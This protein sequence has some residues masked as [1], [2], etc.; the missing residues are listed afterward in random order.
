MSTDSRR[1]HDVSTRRVIAPVGRAWRRR[2]HI[3]VM[4]LWLSGIL[5][6]VTDVAAG[7]TAF[8]GFLTG[9]AAMIGSAKGTAIV[10]LLATT[11]VTAVAMTLAARGSA[12]A[13]VVWLGGLG[14]I[15]Y[16]AQMFVYGTPLNSLFLLYVAALGLSVWSIVWLTRSNT[17]GVVAG[18]V[19]DWMPV[20]PIAVYVWAVAAVNALAWLR[21]LVPALLSADPTIVL[22]GTGLTTNPVYVQDLAFW[23]PLAMVAGVW[24]WRRR[25]AGYVIVGALLAMWVLESISVAVDQW[26]GYRGDPSST[27]VSLTM[28][29]VFGAL[30]AVG[31]LV[32]VI[33][34][35][36]VEPQAKKPLHSG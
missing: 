12:R 26:F 14:T 4:C 5:L 21:V 10:L 34:L 33:H 1:E 22:A 17:I 9:P 18:W 15:L 2:L 32:L 31:L 35:R 13:V 7:L 16:N 30:A 3:P 8:G 36:H 20:R 6:L 28:V 27:V 19:D 23:L 24:L 25:P 29:P 11:P